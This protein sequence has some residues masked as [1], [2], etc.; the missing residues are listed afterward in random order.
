MYLK[1]FLYFVSFTAATSIQSVES[2]QSSVSRVASVFHLIR[3]TCLASTAVALFG[4]VLLKFKLL[5]TAT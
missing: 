3:F 1:S 5:S 4:L 2:I